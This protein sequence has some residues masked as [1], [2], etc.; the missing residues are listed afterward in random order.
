MGARAVAQKSDYDAIFANLGS[1]T[2]DYDGNTYDDNV[3]AYIT[4]GVGGTAISGLYW[5]ATERYDNFAWY[6]GSDYWNY[7]GLKEDNISVRPVLGF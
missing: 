3:N 6:F 5:S 1:T 2:G 4:T 7:D